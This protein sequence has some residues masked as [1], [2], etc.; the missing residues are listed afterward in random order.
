MRRKGRAHPETLRIRAGLAAEVMHARQAL[1]LDRQPELRRVGP[2]DDE[3][4][5]LAEAERLALVRAC[6]YGEE[7]LHEGS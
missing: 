7:D 4:V 2:A 6:G 3:R 5:V 1:V